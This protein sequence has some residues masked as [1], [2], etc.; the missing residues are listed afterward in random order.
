MVRGGG[1]NNNANNCRGANRNNNSPDNENNNL[2]FRLLSTP[3]GKD[4]LSHPRP[5]VPRAGGPSCPAIPRRGRAHGCIMPAAGSPQPGRR[6]A[7]KRRMGAGVAVL[8]AELESASPGR[9]GVRFARGSD[10][11]SPQGG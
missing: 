1:W 10:V 9:G 11:R 2:G 7:M 4:A 5:P 3:H 8:L 6:G